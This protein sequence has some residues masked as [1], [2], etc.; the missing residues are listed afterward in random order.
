[1][2]P[3]ADGIYEE[4]SEPRKRGNLKQVIHVY[5]GE[6]SN[7]DLA[8]VDELRRGKGM[9]GPSLTLCRHQD[10]KPQ[11]VSPQN[12]RIGSPGAIA[13]FAFGTTVLLCNIP[14]A[15]LCEANAYT[16]CMAIF[17]GGFVQFVAG[18]VELVNKNSVGCI[19][20]TG[21]GSYN[22]VLG[23]AALIPTS[24]I[25]AASDAFMGAFFLTWMFFAIT[26]ML[27]CLPGPIFGTI[28]NIFI[29]INFFLSAVSSW[30]TNDALSY[31]VGYEGIVAGAMAVYY[32]MAQSVNGAYQW[33]VFPLGY[34]ERF[35]NFRR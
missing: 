35:R 17:V 4:L 32:G 21:Y 23:V 20:C 34:H 33:N 9:N 2:E 22:F 28:L 6:D 7:A 10:Q 12:P 14:I 25:P 11:E 24:T 31:F 18:Y 3:I 5:D 8:E 13:L 16:T 27:M 15:G 30:V 29:V 19:I 26:V 1:M